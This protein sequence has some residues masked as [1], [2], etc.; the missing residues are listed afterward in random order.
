MTSRQKLDLLVCQVTI[1]TTV[2]AQSK[3]RCWTLSDCPRNS[4]FGPLEFLRAKRHNLLRMWRSAM[5][6][7]F[8]HFKASSSIA[9][10]SLTASVGPL[11]RLTMSARRRK[12]GPPRSNPAEGPHNDTGFLQSPSKTGART[13]GCACQMV[14]YTNLS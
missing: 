14:R 12:R 2:S 8:Y 11:N 5:L 9:P 10:I 7:L 3:I 13:D 6:H 1:L 4:G